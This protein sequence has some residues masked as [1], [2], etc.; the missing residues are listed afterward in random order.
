MYPFGEDFMDTEHN[1]NNGFDAFVNFEIPYAGRRF[2]HVWV[3]NTKHEFI[4]G[5]VHNY[6]T[7][8]IMKHECMIIGLVYISYFLVIYIIFLV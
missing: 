2:S 1:N 6:L 5:L 7:Y 4:H 3:S 8:V